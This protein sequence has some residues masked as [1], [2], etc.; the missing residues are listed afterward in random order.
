MEN[1]IHLL[2]EEAN[3]PLSKIMQGIN[4]SYTQYFNTKYEKVGHLFQGRYK[5]ILCDKNRYL[6]VLIR[7]IHLNSVR[8]FLVERPEDYEWS[9][10]GI[11]LSNETG[12]F[13][14]TDFVLSQFAHTK[15]EAVKRYT[16]FIYEGIGEKVSPNFESGHFLAD[17]EFIESIKSKFHYQ[18]KDPVR[19][20]LDEITFFVT[21][22]F[23]VF[24][25]QL[26]SKSRNRQL[27]ETRGIISYI[28]R[29][30]ADK[31]LKEISDYFN[32]S[33]STISE[34]IIQTEQKMKKEKEFCEQIRYFGDRI[35][36]N[37]NTGA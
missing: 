6:L 21:K 12:S 4:Q 5:A 17:D 30:F 24:E 20:S 22:K 37:R 27:S 26:F 29:E 32:R 9:S 7:Y 19:V 35:R 2:I 28:A 13:V 8:A 34:S 15:K 18:N 1:H 16:E 3:T 33:I 14:D 23:P 11:Y 31:P 25:R 36:N 10:H